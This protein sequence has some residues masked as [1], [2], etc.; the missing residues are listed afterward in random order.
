ME[1]EPSVG[2]LVSGAIQGTAFG[3][4]SFLLYRIGFGQAIRILDARTWII[5]FLIFA[6]VDYFFAPRAM[7]YTKLCQD[8]IL[9][10]VYLIVYP[11]LQIL[12]PRTPRPPKN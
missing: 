4:I 6:A 9:V 7:L 3:I 5:L 11:G 2:N 12:R 10:T 1:W 8:V